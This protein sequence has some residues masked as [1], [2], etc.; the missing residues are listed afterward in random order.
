MKGMGGGM[1][2]LMRQANQMQNRMKKIQEELSSREF[3]GSSG[4][5]AVLVKV[6]GDSLIQTIIIQ[7]E[8]LEAG[9]VEMLQ[10][11]VMT[12]ANEAIK[13]AKEVSQK[14]MDK[15]TGGLSVPGMF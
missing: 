15:I 11:M 13:M 12:A 10:D 7:S 1:Q 14:E 2:Q 6:N 5:G 4:G 8:V 3:E 9:D